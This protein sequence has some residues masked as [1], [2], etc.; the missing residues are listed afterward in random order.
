MATTAPTTS[1]IPT[2]FSALPREVRDMIYPLV[3]NPEEVAKNIRHERNVAF[4][5]RPPARFALAMLKANRD[6][7]SQAR[8]A[9]YKNYT[10]I[11]VSTHFIWLIQALEEL[12]FACFPVS[13]KTLGRFR[14]SSLHMAIDHMHVH[15]ETPSLETHLI[16]MLR[17]LPHFCL[18][19][20]WVL[21]FLDPARGSTASSR[22][23]RFPPDMPDKETTIALHFM[24]TEFK[25]RDPTRDE[26]LLSHFWD[27]ISDSTDVTVV[28]CSSDQRDV[29]ALLSRVTPKESSFAAVA[30]H[31]LEATRSLNVLFEA[32][33]C[34]GD[35]SSAL[36]VLNFMQRTATSLD[37]EYRIR[38]DRSQ[39]WSSSGDRAIKRIEV[40]DLDCI[41]SIVYLRLKRGEY[42]LA[43]SAARDLYRKYKGIWDRPDCD[44]IL[45]RSRGH[46]IHPEVERV[47]NLMSLLTICWK[48]EPHHYNSSVIIRRAEKHQQ[49]MPRYEPF[50]RDLEVMQDLH[51]DSMVR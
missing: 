16:F 10:F 18:A 3:L 25:E 2:N 30:W 37:L 32:A 49:W 14:H 6:I 26:M 47:R 12:S 20:R 46:N 28:N 7:G 19:L 1:R 43:R 9:L 50:R 35:L 44:G 34:S 40:I 15:R 36:K 31:I 8:E 27:C 17:D 23:Q 4:A 29:L 48:P 33:Y 5:P 22:L 13:E 42:R 11:T 45:P 38:G 24:E 51:M 39:D 41:A 21:Y